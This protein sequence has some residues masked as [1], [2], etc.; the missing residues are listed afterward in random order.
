[1]LAG[2]TI[3]FAFTLIKF[4]KDALEA[5]IRGLDMWWEI[6]FPSLLPF[7]IIADLL[8]SFGVVRFLGVIFE[9]VMRPLFN[10]PGSGSFAWIMGMASGY[11]TGAKIS[12]RLREE[13]Q[14]SQ[15]EAERLVSFTN[16][17]SPL[18]IFGAISV[19]FFHDPKL[20]ILLATCHYVGNALV[21][22]CMRFYGRT[23]DQ[24]NKTYKPKQ[25]T[26]LKRAFTEMH[27][28]RIKDTRPLG[29]VMGDA[30]LNSIKT[31]VMVGGFI[32]LFSVLT[33]LL[34]LIEITPIIAL[35]FQQ[36]FILFGLPVELAL[37]FISGLF[38]ITIGANLVSKESMDPF[39]A[40]II[41]VSFI[42]GF[43]GFSV[44]AQVASII[45][46]TDI[47][48]A[49][50]FFARILH[51]F[52]A[53]FLIILLYRPLYVNRQVFEMDEVPVSKPIQQDNM[54][55]VLEQISQIGP[56][57]TIVFLA[58]AV[59]ISLRRMNNN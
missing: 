7:F 13:K 39:L 1:M 24:K 59:Y 55:Q 6:V 29:E 44:Q 32:I 8:L 4:P 26:S 25:K 18:F 34:F 58:L 3:F 14:L 40:S 16:A 22:I 5:S 48:F 38:E 36:I 53:S 28:T 45:S 51:G 35:V 23:E 57:I 54:Y 27:E 9:P 11:P 2:F 15:I 42:L 50:Y 10:V 31:L 17:S 20:G 21:G 49:P 41:V 19:G 52:I 37:P 12:V 46:K 47:R 33:K 56:L 30:V 43:N